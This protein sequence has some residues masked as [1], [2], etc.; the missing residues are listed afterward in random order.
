MKS[1]KGFSFTELL[2]VIAIIGVLA[3]IIVPSVVRYLDKGKENYDNKLSLELETVAKIYFSEHKDQLPNGRPSYS[4]T[5][6]ASFL[7]DNNYFNTEFKDSG[8]NNCLNSYV[9]VEKEDNDYKYITCIVCDNDGYR[10]ENDYCNLDSNYLTDGTSPTCKSVTLTNVNKVKNDKYINEDL[11]I[12]VDAIDDGGISMYKINDIVIP[13]QNSF[14]YTMPTFND[15]YINVVVTVYDKAGNNTI[16]GDILNYIIDKTPP[17]VELDLSTRD[18]VNTDIY[19]TGKITDNI[20][21]DGYQ[22]TTDNK[23]PTNWIKIDGISYDI[24]HKITSNNIYYVW[25]IDKA[26]NI[27]KEKYIKVSN[28]DKT[29]P[30]CYLIA[31]DSGVKITTS[32]N[33]S[34]VDT[35]GLSTGSSIT[36]NKTSSLS[37]SYN[38]FYGFVKDKAGNVGSCSKEV[39]KTTYVYS[40]GC[41]KG[42]AE[43]GNSCRKWMSYKSCAS[44]GCSSYYYYCS[45]GYIQNKNIKSYCHKTYSTEAD[46]GNDCGGTC[47]WGP[48]YHYNNKVYVCSTNYYAN[49]KCT[50]YKSC[51]SCGSNYQ[52]KDYEDNSYYSCG[53]YGKINNSYCYK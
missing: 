26:G 30:T 34:G 41:P 6:W 17:V 47:F 4:K 1:K 53:G 39:F 52:Y 33:L 2:V 9:M 43:Y 49:S 18:Y 42:Y 45:S 11:T 23:V 36:Y 20:A 32:D 29:K 13:Y 50:A 22:V 5:V 16:C 37:L 27:S 19:I 14:T 44:C 3:G 38:T 40:V 48:S 7:K 28:I 51:A 15:G 35:Y 24:K 8:D 31:D 46:C 21:L 12:K 25:A 10:T